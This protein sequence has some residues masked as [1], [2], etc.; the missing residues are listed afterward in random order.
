MKRIFSALLA[1]IMLTQTTAVLSQVLSVDDLLPSFT[2][3]AAGACEKFD[4]ILDYSAEFGDELTQLIEEYPVEGAYSQIV[5]DTE[6]NTI[7]KDDNDEVQLSE[8]DADYTAVTSVEPVIPAVAVLSQ[9]GIEASLDETTGEVVAIV[10]GEEEAFEFSAVDKKTEKIIDSENAETTIENGVQTIQ[11]DGNVVSRDV[12][13]MTVQEAEESFGYEVEYNDGKITVVNPYQAKRLIVRT[14]E[15]KTLKNTYSALQ[16]VSSGNLN[17]LQFETEAQ[18]REAYEELVNDRNILCVNHDRVIKAS[19]LSQRQGANMIQSDRYKK[20]L[21]DNGKT[22]NIVVAVIDTGVDASHPFLKSRVLK[23]TNYIDNVH[24][25]GRGDANGHGTHVAGI[26]ADNTPSN[27][28]ILPIKALNG[29]GMG[30]IFGIINGINYAVKQGAKVINLSLGCSCVG[31]GQCDLEDAVNAAIKKGVTVVVAAGNECLNTKNFCPAKVDAAIT[32]AAS[33]SENYEISDYSNYGDAVDLAAP[34][35]SILSCQPGGGYVELSGTSMATPFVAAAAAMLLTENSKLKPSQVQEKLRASC[36]DIYTK[37]WDRYSGCGILNL[38]IL[39]G[40]KDIYGDYLVIS[41]DDV[42]MAYFTKVSWL[43]RNATVCSSENLHLTDASVTVSSSDS[44]VATFNGRYVYPKKPGTTT[45]T[46]KYRDTEAQTFKVNITKKEVWIDYKADEYAGGDGSKSKPYLI[47]TASQLAKFSYDIRKS[48]TANKKYYKLVADI[49]LKGKDWI[50]ATYT[51]ANSANMI[52]EALSG[53]FLFK[54]GF[55]GNNHKIKN[56]NVFSVLPSTIWGEYRTVNGEWYANNGGFIGS[57]SGATIKNLG[58]ENAYCTNKLTG[59][60]CDGVLQNSTISQCYTTGFSA[61]NGLAYAIYNYNIKVLN[62]F[63]TADVVGNGICEYIYSS[64]SDGDVIVANTYFGGNIVGVSSTDKSN[65]N[66]GNFTGSVES[67]SGYNHT[68]IYNC[69]TTASDRYRNGFINTNIDSRIY[70]CYGVSGSLVGTKKGSTKNDIK[71][72]ELSKL[73]QKSTYT[74]SSNWDSKYKWD[75]NNIWAIS[76]KVNN[77]LPYLKKMQPSKTVASNTGTWIDSAS[78]SFAGGD[79]TFKSPYLVSTAGQLARIAKLYRFG[80]GQGIYFKLTN[81]IDLSEKT[82]LPIGVGAI[83]DAQGFNLFFDSARYSFKGNIYGDGH[84]IKGLRVETHGDYVGFIS[85]CEKN[86]IY[87]LKFA[88][89]SVSGNDYVGGICGYLGNRSYVISCDFRGEVKGRDNIGGLCAQGDGA[90]GVLGCNGD[91]R[92]R[93]SRNNDVGMAAGLCPNIN[94]RVEN[95]SI[96]CEP[97]ESSNSEKQT[98]NVIGGPGLIK[99][100]YGKMSVEMPQMENSGQNSYIITGNKAIIYGNKYTS[101]PKTVNKLSNTKQL[102]EKDFADFDFSDNWQ[103]D[104]TELGYTP[105]L[106]RKSIKITGTSVPSKSWSSYE[107]KSFTAGSGTMS[108]PYLISSAG[109]LV[110]AYNLI[111]KTGAKKTLYF[112]LIKNIDL[113]GKKWITKDEDWFYTDICYGFDGNNKTVSNMIT[114]NGCG[115]LP[116]GNTGYIRHLKVKNVSGYTSCG[117]IGTNLGKIINCYVSGTFTAPN[118]EVG[119]I[120]KYNYSDGIIEKCA[121]YCNI[122]G[123]SPSGIAPFNDGT[124]RNCSIKGTFGYDTSHFAS[125]NNCGSVK[126]CLVYADWYGQDGFVSELDETDSYAVAKTNREY[127][128]N[129]GNLK[130]LTE[131]RSESTYQ[132]WDFK[133]TWEINP[134]KNSGLPYIRG[135]KSKKI[136]Y[137]LPEGA[138]LSYGVYDYIPGTTVCLPTASMKSKIF[139][140]WYTSSKFKGEPITKITSSYKNDVTLYPKWRS[141]YILVLVSDGKKVETVMPCNESVAIPG[142]LVSKKGYTLVG[143]ATKKGGSVK[144]KPTQKV[145]NLAK[146]GKTVTLYAVWKKTK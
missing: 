29:D 125:V 96:L 39:L 49:D 25:D 136:T 6:K 12:G 102:T 91:V 124:I 24:K 63:S 98:V 45:I 55:D 48:K 109:Q 52:G 128:S 120:C 38:G 5:I 94:F 112:R 47:K 88:D 87:N 27:V 142:K 103:A 126:N 137:V 3:K 100:C 9:G 42:N 69:F 66:L 86:K 32:V 107:S 35:T 58:I 62:C 101:S 117:I 16:V 141:G 145:K 119:G 76:S 46:V 134:D 84:T 106:K 92:V 30:T 108:S 60:L 83:V 111:L 97:M 37:G 138:K 73:K 132:N 144:Y 21:K 68:K 129:I 19:A 15:G 105:K 115:L 4:D 130:N 11:V 135:L 26:I 90:A 13:Y 56:M 143:W 51:P 36:T 140:G 93:A 1:V 79:G 14:K 131:M 44:S 65:G 71:T 28:K 74:N 67:N 57:I 64:R 53:E 54:G 85:L 75:F 104:T 81:D 8:Y 70:K 123:D 72:T 33:S 146:S 116:S 127:K 40:D 41:T 59:I 17:V 2:V 7:K 121:V 95:C 139:E 77:G 22:T 61:G 50:T 80:G 133:K 10:D 23:G 99:N 43:M 113:S 82:W 118:S 122:I 114:S 110:K 34:G 31:S 20:H 18:T 89:A 78:S